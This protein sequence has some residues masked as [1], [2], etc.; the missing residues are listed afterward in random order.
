[1]FTESSVQNISFEK[2]SIAGIG[3][4][5]LSEAIRRYLTAEEWE[6]IYLSVSTDPGGVLLDVV[7]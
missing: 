5:S 1:M 7:I 2:P 6:A 4:K 3:L